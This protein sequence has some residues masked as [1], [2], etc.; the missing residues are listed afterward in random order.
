MDRIFRFWIDPAEAVRRNLKDWGDVRVEFDLSGVSTGD[1]ELLASAL[2][3]DSGVVRV[4][5]FE[6]AC[7]V[8]RAR[9]VMLTTKGS[10][11]EDVLDALRESRAAAEERAEEHRRAAEA[12]K[13]RQDKLLAEAEEH[14]AETLRTRRLRYRDGRNRLHEAHLGEA[15]TRCGELVTR[16]SPEWAAVEQELLDEYLTRQE[17]EKAAREAAEKERE[18]L[19]EEE[20]RK[21]CEEMR[22]WVE[23]HGSDHL[24]ACLAEGFECEKTYFNERLAK[25]FPG[26]GLKADVACELEKPIDPSPEALEMLAV[27]RRLVADQTAAG[28]H[29]PGLMTG[30]GKHAGDYY[31]LFRPITWSRVGVLMMKF[32]PPRC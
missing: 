14:D 31:A 23:A 1:R 22:A 7:G 16:N 18:R 27:A 24:R 19:K 12:Q 25:E 32:G 30:T 17:A 28:G 13:A 21:A 9:R 5:M 8:V 6:Y 10:R 20:D 26:W 3:D 11:L 4:G 15:A 29:P 2:F